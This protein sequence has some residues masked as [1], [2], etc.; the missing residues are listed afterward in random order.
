MR[1]RP[2]TAR[3]GL[4][5]ACLSI[6]MAVDS[7]AELSQGQESLRGVQ[8]I[9]IE[10]SCSKE[11]IEA[12]LVEKDEGK[13]IEE[14]I[15]Q[16]GVKVM[17]KQLL[18]TVP[19]RCRLQAT[20]QIYKPSGLDILICDLRLSFIQTATLQR[21]PK[22]TVDATTW[23]LTRLAHGSKS[24]IVQIVRDNLKTMAE[25]FI[26][27]YVVANP[28]P[29]EQPAGADTPTQTNAPSA[30]DSGSETAEQRYIAS[31][32]SGVFHKP[33]CRWA[34]N[35]SAANL[36]TYKSKDEAIKDGKRPCKSCNP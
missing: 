26:E 11:A 18:G 20:I 19:G 14:Q 13:A 7:Y 28:K 31:K 6:L 1:A 23:E 30:P 25:S 33:G 8:A 9:T 24:E 27:D 32:S 35:I 34:Q 17:P 12:G 22:T 4:V 21:S 10:A 5:V 15:V 29:A 3:T 36:M 2:K 16:A